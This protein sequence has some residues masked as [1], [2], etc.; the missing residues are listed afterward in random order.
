LVLIFQQ[1]IIQ[2]TS[3]CVFNAVITSFILSR[4][5]S[6]VCDPTNNEIPD[7]LSRITWT[8]F[9][10]KDPTP[11][12]VFNEYGIVLTLNVVVPDDEVFR[13]PP[14]LN[15]PIF[16]DIVFEI[17][18][19]AET[20]KLVVCDAQLI[21]LTEFRDNESPEV[22]LIEFGPGSDGVAKFVA[23]RM[24][25]VESVN[26][27][28][29]VVKYKFPLFADNLTFPVFVT[30]TDPEVSFV[31]D[32]PPEDVSDVR[33]EDTREIEFVVVEGIVT[34]GVASNIA[35]VANDGTVEF[36]DKYIPPD[37]ERKI[38]FPPL[39]VIVKFPDVWLVKE[40]PETDVW[41]FVDPDL[42]E[43]TVPDVSDSEFEETIP[44]EFV[45]GSINVDAFVASK[46]EPF[47]FVGNVEFVDRYKYPFS[48]TI[49]VCPFVGALFVTYIGE[50][51]VFRIFNPNLDSDLVSPWEWR[52]IDCVP[53][54]AIVTPEVA[55]KMDPIERTGIAGFVLKYRFAV[56]ET[57]CIGPFETLFTILFLLK[58]HLKT[59]GSNG[60][61]YHFS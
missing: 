50:E 11:E 35:P 3:P 49:C 19:P 41:L 15:I 14:E 43:K 42:T 7:N 53:G 10:D 8:P 25:P 26:I 27:V 30:I 32:I 2:F 4:K 22:I 1:K 36:V 33:P 56:S 59:H 48:D 18:N 55:I 17:T 47:E 44:I 29:F 61:F 39:L 57:I 46:I 51:P 13:F 45:P 60:I 52:N 20:E 28:G 37:S 58:P 21:E 23:R 38:E 40:S 34:D 6:F 9:I 54:S 12:F 16:P 5:L 24:L 31:K